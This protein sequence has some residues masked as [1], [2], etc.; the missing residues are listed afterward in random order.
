MKTKKIIVL[1][2]IAAIIFPNLSARATENLAERLAGKI[3][4]QVESYGRAWYINPTTKERYYLQDGNAAYDLMRQLSLGISN[5][6]LA[7]IPIKRGAKSDA[8]LVNRLKGKILLQVESHGEAWYVNPVDGLRYYLKDGNAA[9]DL[10][11]KFAIGIKDKDLRTIPMN[12]TQRVMDT[13]FDDVAHVSFDGTNYADQYHADQIL[14]PAS[15]TKL[16]TALVLLDQQLDWNQIVTIMPEDIA[17]PKI[18]VG[19]DTTSEIDI[20]IGDQVSIGD[21]WVAMLVSSSNQAAAAL[22]R[23]TGLAKQDFVALMNQ[24]AE[25]LGLKKT[26]FYDVAGLDSHDVTTPKEMA[27]IAYHAF[28]IPKIADTSIIRSYTL[29]VVDAKGSAKA[30]KATNRNYSLLAF[31]PQGAKTGYL[32]EAKCTVA[33]KINNV[34]YVVMH[35]NHV[36]NRNNI[37]K[38]IITD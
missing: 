21:L 30:V 26:Y 2:A 6:D 23:V 8:K 14:A 12:K 10:M 29:N 19:D 11:K 24:K 7:N 33:V 16:M 37:L 25:N 17:Y 28:N 13:T 27:V 9:Y 4:L 36:A 22:T 31:N 18:F 38:K 3:L 15:M 35:A 1:A 34:I 20:A 5:K 32:V